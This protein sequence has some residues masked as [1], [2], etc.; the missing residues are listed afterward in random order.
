MAKQ[1]K[2]SSA[3]KVHRTDYCGMDGVNGDADQEW[4]DEE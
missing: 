3:S 2:R 4:R 1:L